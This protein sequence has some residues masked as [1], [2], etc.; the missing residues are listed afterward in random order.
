MVSKLV[1]V[2][3]IGKIFVF[4][5][6]VRYCSWIWHH[7]CMTYPTTIVSTVHFHRTLQMI[8]L[9]STPSLRLTWPSGSFCSNQLSISQLES[10]RTT[11]S[12]QSDLLSQAFVPNEVGS[13]ESSLYAERMVSHALSPAFRLND[14]T[15]TNK[16]LVPKAWN[17]SSFPSS[18]VVDSPM[19]SKMKF[20][21]DRFSN[22][23]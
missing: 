8:H 22:L 15:R 13:H 7:D 10:S 19:T 18:V 1:N 20:F 12:K 5:Q 16:A 11:E 23:A 17:W 14:S 4:P 6:E 2:G 9:P 21:L 3:S